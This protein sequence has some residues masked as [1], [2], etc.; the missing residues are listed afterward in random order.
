MKTLDLV[1]ET[2]DLGRKCRFKT[3]HIGHQE[4]LPEEIG[5]YT[6]SPGRERGETEL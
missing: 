3:E 2:N 6:L 1:E 5:P 4:V